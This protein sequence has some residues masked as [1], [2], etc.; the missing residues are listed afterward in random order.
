MAERLGKVAEERAGFPIDLFGVQP[1][2]V[3]HPDQLVD[4][5][6]RFLEPALARVRFGEPERTSHECA[7]LAGK[8]VLAEV[9]RHQWPLSEFASDRVDR[10]AQSWRK[11]IVVAG[12][13]P[14]EQRAVER[15]FVGAARVAA[16][17]PRITAAL[18]EIAD[19]VALA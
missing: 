2:V 7:V 19:A 5:G 14:E 3:R 18:D 13:H 8:A 16:L 9:P 12:D 17:V 11:R 6:R 15:L 1:D 4:Q 10:S